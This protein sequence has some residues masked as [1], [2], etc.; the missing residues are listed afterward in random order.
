MTGPE[1]MNPD[2]RRRRAPLEQADPAHPL[3]VDWIGASA[4][5]DGARGRLGLTFL[6]GKHG[7][8]SRYPG[9]EYARDLASDLAALDA[10]GVR[11]L[12]LLVEDHEL[13]RWGDPGIVEL[14][15]ARGITV[16]RFP[17]PDGGTPAT[18]EAMGQLLGELRAARGRGDVAVACMGGVGRTGTV[19]ACALVAGGMAPSDA[20]EEIRRVRHPD[21]VETREQRRFVDRFAAWCH[22]S[23]APG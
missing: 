2:E 7:T 4:L 17:L 12:L 20:I 5:A 18:L 19:A 15:G 11:Y 9:L 13:A 14:A 21:A 10:L 16:R 8:S 22:A 6:P 1:V 3:R 23:G